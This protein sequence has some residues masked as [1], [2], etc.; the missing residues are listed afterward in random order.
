MNT[1]E[2]AAFNTYSTATDT[3]DNATDATHDDANTFSGG[4]GATINLDR[5]TIA[6]NQTTIATYSHAASDG[7][8]FVR[9][10]W[11]VLRKSSRRWWPRRPRARW[12]KASRGLSSSSTRAARCRMR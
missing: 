6:T 9:V 2:Q 11:D 4:Y 1:V 3:Y 12:R 5:N 7:L 10:R 8:E